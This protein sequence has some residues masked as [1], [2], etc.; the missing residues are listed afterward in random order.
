MNIGNML[1]AFWDPGIGVGFVHAL[2]F[3]LN[4]SFI[5]GGVTLL[6]YMCR[7]LRTRPSAP[8]EQFRAKPTAIHY[9]TAVIITILLICLSVFNALDQSQGTFVSGS[10]SFFDLLR[11][12]TTILDPLLDISH[13]ADSPIKEFFGLNLILRAAVIY[14][15]AA[16]LPFSVKQVRKVAV[17]F[18]IFLKEKLLADPP[19]DSVSAKEDK[20]NVSENEIQILVGR[21][22]KFLVSGGATVFAAFVLGSDGIRENI[23]EVLKILTD[24]ISTMTL[25][26]NVGTG[27]GTSGFFSNVLYILLS[28]A[29]LAIYATAALLLIIFIHTVLKNWSRISAW[30][31]EKAKKMRVGIAGVLL[32]AASLAIIIGAGVCL[33]KHAFLQLNF[34]GGLSEAIH[35]V[36][37]YSVVILVIVLVLL[38]LIVALAFLALTISYARQV[39]RQKSGEWKNGFASEKYWRI[40]RAAACVILAGILLI[41]VALCYEKLRDW[42]IGI[43][44]SGEGIFSPVQ[45]FQHAA[46]FAA[47]L[48]GLALLTATAAILGV[49]VLWGIIEFFLTTRKTVITAASRLVRETLTVLLHILSL[50]PFFFKQAG[51]L[52]KSVILLLKSVLQTVLQIFTGYRTESDKNNAIF[53]AACFAS[54]ASLLNT[55][56]GLY[57]FYGGGPSIS[58][59]D[60]DDWIRTICTLAIACAAQLA[61]LVFGMKAGEGLTEWRITDGSDAKDKLIRVLVRAGMATG[62][63]AS[64][65]CL[66]AV[67]SKFWGSDSQLLELGRSIIWAAGLI[68]A[69]CWLYRWIKGK[70]SR[71]KDRETGGRQANCAEEIP[72]TEVFSSP[73]LP[74]QRQKRQRLPFYWYLAVYLL[75]MIIS[76]G[77][78]YSN[79]FG[80]YAHGAK[81]HER[82]YSQVRYE[83]DHTLQLSENVAKMVRAYA[84]TTRE[85]GDLFSTRAANAIQARDSI[86]AELRGRAE[87][88]PPGEYVEENRRDRFI[89][90]TKDLEQVISNIQSILTAQYDTIG[91]NTSI[92]VEEYAHYWGYSPQPSYSTTCIVIHLNGGLH[93]SA[94]K[95][96]PNGEIITVGDFIPDVNMSDFPASA[97]QSLVGKPVPPGRIEDPASSSQSVIKTT[98]YVLHA[99]KYD[100]LKQLF[101]QYERMENEIYSYKLPNGGSVRGTPSAPSSSPFSQSY[102]AFTGTVVTNFLAWKQ[103]DA[104]PTIS[105][106]IYPGLDENAQRDGIRANI[107]ALYQ[108]SIQG[109]GGSGTTRSSPAPTDTSVTMPELPRIT[110]AYLRGDD[111]SGND[112]SSGGDSQ[113]GAGSD[114]KTALPEYQ[115]LSDYID[116]ALALNNILLS[117]DTTDKDPSDGDSPAYKTQQYRNYARGIAYLE[118]QVSYDAL[119]RGHLKLNPVR[120]EIDALYTTSAI[121]TFLL[122]ICLLIDLLAFF[123]GLLLF[124]RIY[125]FGKNSGILQMGYLNYEIAL[126]YLFAVPKDLHRR[127]LHL[128]FMYKVLYGDASGSAASEDINIAERSLDNRKTET[129][130][131]IPEASRGLDGADPD[132]PPEEADSNGASDEVSSEIPDSSI[133]DEQAPA[134]EDPTEPEDPAS[135]PDSQP[136]SAGTSETEETPPEEDVP[137]SGTDNKPDGGVPQQEGP[138]PPEQNEDK[139]EDKNAERIAKFEQDMDYLHQVMRSAD[140][141]KLDENMA[142]VL[143]IL[144]ITEYSNGNEEQNRSY[145]SLQLWLRNFI[146]ENDITFDELFPPQEEE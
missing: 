85:L 144:G 5:V 111:G 146:E 108:T 37:N 81:I 61:M 96:S 115:K 82:V 1:L 71:Q 43:F 125:L 134:G 86:I 12:I 84:E 33:Q 101:T 15:L 133:L 18:N 47:I 21:L 22:I 62:V 107:A 99:D 30:L 2:L 69:V 102:A 68:L 88:E 16:A 129:E 106:Q 87:Q 126:S 36:V 109:S 90:L 6:A 119:F 42:L 120:D 139:Q 105:K 70:R 31:V 94:I 35:I 116:R 19:E 83:A 123:S 89:G 7:Y 80:Y 20:E 145:A 3:I 13:L 28:L 9:I 48:G 128:A 4:L 60:L 45:V 59:F 113:D 34:S 100:I 138:H 114:E 11:F 118:F 51:L 77:F 53:M 46:V 65:G 104:T 54:L 17:Q 112:T 63:V 29:L 66:Y 58:E 79:L 131:N 136:A 137:T 76:T 40:A 110:E 130:E 127:K 27:T 135:A 142:A 24:I 25:L 132:A 57:Q 49:I 117:F 140:S 91:S 97:H 67:C 73:L 124:K 122:L 75:L 55:F 10:Y 50:V 103:T 38:L 39:V 8:L 56:F 98:R 121:A 14:I 143:K 23:S 95:T 26:S 52:A 72:D 41:T 78:A 93:N 92:V 44:N 141:I 64:I 74:G 32:M